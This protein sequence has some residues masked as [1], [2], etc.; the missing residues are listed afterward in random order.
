MNMYYIQLA[1]MLHH[2]CFSL[3]QPP[4]LDGGGRVLDKSYLLDAPKHSVTQVPKKRLSDSGT[5][6]SKSKR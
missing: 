2:G 3:L 1:W 5:S 4:C 6:A